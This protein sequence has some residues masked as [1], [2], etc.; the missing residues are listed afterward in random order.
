MKQV[1]KIFLFSETFGK[2]ISKLY[3]ISVVDNVLDNSSDKNLFENVV[4]HLIK[5]S[6]YKPNLNE[7]II[8]DFK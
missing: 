6:G 4:N 1:S 8:Y 7:K 5:L 3:D 2:R